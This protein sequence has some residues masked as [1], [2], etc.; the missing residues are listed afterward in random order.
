M[1]CSCSCLAVCVAKFTAIFS[2]KRE[3]A[4]TIEKFLLAETFPGFPLLA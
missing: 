1:L 2:M 3:K 4:K